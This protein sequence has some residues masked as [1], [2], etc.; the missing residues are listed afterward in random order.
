MIKY[1][2][3]RDL[4]IASHISQSHPKLLARVCVCMCIAIRVLKFSFPPLLLLILPSFLSPSKV[5]S[6]TCPAR[7]FFSYFTTCIV[8][9]YSSWKTVFGVKFLF[10]FYSSVTSSRQLI[11]SFSISFIC[12]GLCDRSSDTYFR[13]KERE[14]K[15][16]Y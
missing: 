4:A 5:K 7:I 10:S 9:T 2:E 8:F 6:T 16:R 12:I 15:T 14:E 1:L 11:H 13:T 3:L